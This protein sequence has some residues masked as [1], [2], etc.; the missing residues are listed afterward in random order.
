MPPNVVEKYGRNDVT[1]TEQLALA[2]LKEFN[3]TWLDVK[4]GE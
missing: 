1:I 2:Q 4:N 3:I